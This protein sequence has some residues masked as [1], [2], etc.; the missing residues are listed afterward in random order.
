MNDSFTFT[1]PKNEVYF[2]AVKALLKSKGETQLVELLND[3]KCEISSTSRYSGKRWD[4]V[5]AKIVFSV[6]LSKLDRYNESIKEKLRVICDVAM[7]ASV[8]YDIME[9]QISPL[10]ENIPEENSLSEDLEELS[11]ELTNNFAHSFPDDILRKG[12]DMAEVY[13][14][15][16]FIENTL[17]L[18]IETEAKKQYGDKWQTKLIINR[19]IRQSIE[20]R[21]TAEKQNKWLSIRGQSDL[22]F[23]DF[24][25]L[26]SIISSNWDMFKQ[27]FPDLKWIDSKIDELANCR[28]LVAHNS[29]LNSDE[30]ALIRLYYHNI[31]KQIGYIK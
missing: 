31:L 12:K 7:P 2:K 5:Y 9:I 23:V 19:S 14:Y 27:F 29:Y 24:K 22:F 18:L 6:P 30:K 1:P 21:R 3:A 10:I 20:S 4:A 26:G 28:N 16:Y 15:L 8:G 11:T 17:R 13:L 25:D